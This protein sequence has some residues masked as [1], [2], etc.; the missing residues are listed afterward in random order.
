MSKMIPKNNNQIATVGQADFWGASNL[1]QNDFAV[2]RLK[3][4][5]KKENAGKFEMN[6]GEVYT[7]MVG[8]KLLVPRKTRVLYGPTTKSPSRCKSDDYY[9][10][11]P[12][13]KGP[14]SGNC[15]NCYA[16]QWGDSDPKKIALFKELNRTGKLMNPLCNETYNL[17]MADANWRPF[18]ISFQKTGLKTVQEKLFSKMKT[19][20][21]APF[22][23]QFDMD[24]STTTSPNGDEYY[25]IEFN[26]FSTA[27]EEDYHKGETLWKN[28]SS[29]AA[30]MFAK[31]HEAMDQEKIV[32]DEPPTPT[33][34]DSFSGVNTNEEI[35]F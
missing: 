9:N 20:D 6:N 12:N 7:S 8:C 35:P 5:H 3:L 11:S 24:I 23:V 21:C 15:L 19:M 34:L 29:M 4:Q 22:M 27:N 30:T 14:I 33:D 18:S 2:P 28:L 13:T 17:I 10:P 32:G 25:Q 31:E 1:D 16:A 26:N